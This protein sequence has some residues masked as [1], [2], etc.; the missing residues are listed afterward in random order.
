[1]LKLMDVCAGHTTRDWLVLGGLVLNHLI[2]PARAL[3]TEKMI[4]AA[5]AVVDDVNTDDK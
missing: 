4:C 5:L 2:D 3:A 1:M